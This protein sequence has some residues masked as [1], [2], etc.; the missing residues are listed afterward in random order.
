MRRPRPVPRA[1][2]EERRRAR[3]PAGAHRRTSWKLGLACDLP[4]RHMT[5]RSPHVL[6]FG[7]KHTG[8]YSA[9][10]GIPKTEILMILMTRANRNGLLP[11]I[12]LMTPTRP[13]IHSVAQRLTADAAGSQ[14][15]R[16]AA[17]GGAP[18]AAGAPCGATG[19]RMPSA[20]VR[21]LRSRIPI[22]GH[23]LF[24]TLWW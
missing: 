12:L 4:P 20:A 14:G 19:A 2:A 6:S 8:K 23:Y 16:G 11:E 1:R 10:G 5:L 9:A 24:S 17:E 22:S 13:Q 7:S 21:L 3:C 15:D 18:Q